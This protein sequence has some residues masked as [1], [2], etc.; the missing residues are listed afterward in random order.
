MFHRRA[1]KEIPKKYLNTH[2]KDHVSG[3]ALN[4]AAIAPLEA[5]VFVSPN[6]DCF[7]LG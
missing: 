6:A 1:T 7:S 3:G 5:K 4:M 2:E